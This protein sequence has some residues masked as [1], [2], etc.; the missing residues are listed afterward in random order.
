MNIFDELDEYL[1]P[2]YQV[3]YWSDYAI[4]HATELINQLSEE[5][6]GRLEKTWMEREPAWQVRL[7]GA[8]F[9]STQSSVSVLLTE[10]LK[11][12]DVE[13]ALAAAES[14]DAMDKVTFDHS[15]RPFLERLLSHADV[16][17]RQMLE[18]LISRIRE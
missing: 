10:M 16:G 4:D 18:G 6:W 15:L 11:S 8:A 12:P 14:L 17:Y 9:G 1:R 7:A 13:V 5:D 2:D 3:D